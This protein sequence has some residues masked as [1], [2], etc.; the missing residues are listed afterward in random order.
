MAADDVFT[1]LADPTRRE[2]VEALS[3]AGS[4]TATELSSDMPISRQAVAKHLMH[5]RRADLVTPERRGRETRYRLTPRPFGEA[6][7]WLERMSDRAE[8]PRPRRAA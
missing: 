4:C 1:A 5:L 3:R 8:A 2:I 7:A 6:V